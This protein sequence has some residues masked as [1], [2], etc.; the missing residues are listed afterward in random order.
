MTPG[1]AVVV[2]QHSCSCIQWPDATSFIYHWEKK[3]DYAEHELLLAWLRTNLGQ[4][5]IEWVCYSM[6]NRSDILI[7]EP[8]KAM[9]FKVRW[10]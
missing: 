5:G 4:Y 8:K 6:T 2:N 10:G 1:K 3:Y 9:W 7:R